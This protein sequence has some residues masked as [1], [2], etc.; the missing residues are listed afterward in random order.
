[1]P[2]RTC[3]GCKCVR[4]KSSLLRF[5]S[6]GGVLKLDS[7]GVLKGRGA[8]LCLRKE[9]LKEAYRKGLFS[10]TLK[11]KVIL[12]DIEELWRVVSGTNRG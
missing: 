10:R 8:Y 2:Q 3:L 5:V 4:E 9:C 7:R 12:P 11:S 1:M 6:E